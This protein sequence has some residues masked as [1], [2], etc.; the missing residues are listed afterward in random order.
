[1]A[2]KEVTHKKLKHKVTGRVV[3]V[4]V[5][6]A[7]FYEANGWEGV[8]SGH[9]SGNNRAPAGEAADRKSDAKS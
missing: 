2:A 1:M 6:D 7:E 8:T 4:A 5:E 3:N 9:Q